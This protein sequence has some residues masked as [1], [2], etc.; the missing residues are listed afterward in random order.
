M[1]VGAQYIEVEIEVLDELLA[2]HVIDAFWCV[3]DDLG[4]D[5]D[6]LSEE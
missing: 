5:E 2:E 6:G 4:Q 1:I 3:L